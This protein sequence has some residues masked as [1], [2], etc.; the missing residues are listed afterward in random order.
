MEECYYDLDSMKFS[1]QNSNF[2]AQHIQDESKK[3]TDYINKLN[4]VKESRNYDEYEGS[5]NLAADEIILQAVED[6]SQKKKTPKLKYIIDIGIGGS[7]LGT[8]A[9]YD[10]FFGYFD[11]LEPDRYPKMI[12]ADTNDPEFLSKLADFLKKVKDPEEILLNLISKSGTTTESIVNAEIILSALGD[13]G[14]TDEIIYSRT[15]ITTD[16]GSRLWGFAKEKNIDTLEIPKKVG[17]RYSVFSPVALFPLLTVGLDIEKFRDGANFMINHCLDNSLDNPALVSAI[18]LFLASKKNININDNFIFQAELESLGKWYRQLMAE[19]LGKNGKLVLT[20]TVSIGSTDLHS[21]AQLYLGGAI[22][23]IT[24]F[25]SS[26]KPK[27]DVE[28]PNDQI[29]AGLVDG[30]AGKKASDIMKAI[31]EGVK[32]AYQKKQM[33]FLEIVFDQINEYEI[34]QFMQF[35]MIEMMFL[36]QLFEVN[37]FDQPNVEDYKVETKKILNG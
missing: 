1:S 19:S 22:D 2:S 24:T 17:G 18:I 31:L 8:K 11:L 6:L 27:L 10:A 34:G 12:F 15:I 21:M 35:K 13:S 29:F 33:P 20:P 7:N 30:I 9:I 28:I 25:I 16:N 32:I 3:L 26:D 5:I 36:G 23:K 14:M 4:Q 37:A